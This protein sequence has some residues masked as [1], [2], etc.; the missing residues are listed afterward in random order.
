MIDLADYFQVAVEGWEARIYP[1]PFF[2][3]QLTSTT[4]T[5]TLRDLGIVPG[6]TIRF[7]R[8]ST[9]GSL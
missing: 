3:Q 7:R 1:S 9:S 2:D 8:I 6:S 4:A 5:R